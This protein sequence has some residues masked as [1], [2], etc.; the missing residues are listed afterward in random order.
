MEYLET[1]GVAVVGYQTDEL[2]AF[3]TRHSGFGVDYRC[4]TPA[5]IAKALSTK[6]KLQLQG[7]MVI[8]N[9]VPD[10][11]ALESMKTEQIIKRVNQ[12]VLDQGITGKKITPYMLQRIEELTGGNSLHTNIHLVLNNARLGAKISLAYSEITTE[13]QGP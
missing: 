4:D 9:P 8:A 5:E 3:Y 6:W 13:T 2:P 12:E 10:I 11:H 1:M 7:G